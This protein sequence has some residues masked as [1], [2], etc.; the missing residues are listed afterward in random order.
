VLGSLFLALLMGLTGCVGGAWKSALKED[1]SAGYYRFMR[2]HADSK[3][4]D[5]ARERLEYHKLKRSPTLAG[6]A[7]FRNKYPDSELLDA[8]QPSLEKPAFQAALA[9]G[10]SEAYRGFLKKFRRGDLA[11]RAEGNAVYVEAQ[12]FNGDA[13]RLGEF[14]KNYPESDFAAEAQRTADAVAARGRAPI[15]QVGLVMRVDESTPESKRV[16]TALQERIIEMAERMGVQV[17]EVPSPL[18]VEQARRLPTAR[19][20]VIHAEKEVGHEA[21]AGQLA[22]PA[23]LGVTR[24]VLMD[25]DGG[26]IIA[27]RR[28]E[29]RVEDKAHVTGS[30]VLF[31]QSAKK[32]WDDFFVPVVSWRNDQS[33][34]PEIAMQKTVADIEGV[35]D[36]AFV[37]YDNGDFDVIGLA[38][39]AAPVQ[40]ASYERSERLKKWSGIRVVGDR[41]VIFGE[42]GLEFVRFTPA[43]PLAERTWER[44]EIGRI[45]SIAEVGQQLVTVGAKGMQILDLETGEIRRAMRR[46]I[47]SIGSTG[48]TLVFVDGESIYVSTLELLAQDRV[49][50]QMRLGKTFGPKHVRVLDDTAIVTGPGGVVVI[51]VRNPAQ[52][53]ASAKLASREIGEIVDATRVRGRTF[54]LGQRGLQVLNRSLTAVEETID[55]GDRERLTVMGRHLVTADPGGLRVVDTTPWATGAM[56]AA[57]ATRASSRSASSGRSPAG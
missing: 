56:P 39:P 53:K 23:M 13:A 9:Q 1:T 21:S 24:L 38:D 20:E 51:D 30:S 46:V 11:K 4:A 44:G 12:G 28:F 57:K 34:S 41:I 47:Q 15:K 10:T 36:R 27:D 33:V 45:L 35:G 40:L 43:G 50:A 29:V 6:F 3:Y 2:D 17:V 14:A 42:E 19:L 55:V 32:Y 7:A 49:I 8:L 52:P 22:R 37:L 48:E 18:S 5:E 25:K 16:R 26:E 31:S 54:L